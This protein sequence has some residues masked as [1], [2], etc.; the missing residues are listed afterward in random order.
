MSEKT[1]EEQLLEQVKGIRD[2]FEAKEK[3]LREDLVK[4]QEE[5]KAL[6]EKPPTRGII[7]NEAPAFDFELFKESKSGK[8]NYSIKDARK[9][10]GT[11]IY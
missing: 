4:A 5:I 10:D 11:W 2:D 1:I 6:K 7:T 8:T 3:A 9:N